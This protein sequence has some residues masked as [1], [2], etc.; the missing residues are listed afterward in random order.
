MPVGK[1]VNMSLIIKKRFVIEGSEGLL[2]IDPE[3]GLINV[4]I[5]GSDDPHAENLMSFLLADKDVKNLIE[6]RLLDVDTCGYKFVPYGYKYY[7]RRKGG[8]GK[9]LLGM[10]RD[11]CLRGIKNIKAEDLYGVI[12]FLRRCDLDIRAGHSDGAYWFL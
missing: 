8:D 9:V 2:C 7:I 6:G 5:N 12:Q 10:D 4:T 3:D 1:G 11:F